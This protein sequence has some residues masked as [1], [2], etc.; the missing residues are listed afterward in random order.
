M[1]KLVG[2]ENLLPIET[3]KFDEGNLT[4][5]AMS[6]KDGKSLWV[7]V[8]PYTTT[9]QML[10]AKIGAVYLAHKSGAQIIPA[11]L[12]YRGGSVSLE[13]VGNLIKGYRS[14]KKGQAPADYHLGE[15]VG[16]DPVE[17]GIIEEVLRKRAQGEDVS[18][19]TK[20]AFKQ[21][22]AQLKQQADMVAHAIAEMLPAERRGVYSE[23]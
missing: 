14:Q 9:E 23:N 4:E 7:A 1:Y 21:A 17:I 8:H 19:G 18:R 2:K 12:D 20:D 13:G 16:L 5:L 15:P 6:E 11:A 22:H 10:P 3:E